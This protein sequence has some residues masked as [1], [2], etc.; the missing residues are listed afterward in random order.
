MKFKVPHNSLNLEELKNIL[1]TCNSNKNLDEKDDIEIWKNIE[2]TNYSVSTL[3]NICNNNTGRILIGTPNNNGYL[4]VNLYNK[5]YSVHRLVAI[6]FIPNPE[7]KPTVNH[8]TING[9]TNKQDNRA[10]SLEWATHREQNLHASDNGLASIGEDRFNSILDD[11]NVSLIKELISKGIRDHLIAEEFEVSHGTVQGIRF[12]R[13]WRHIPWPEGFN[14]YT[15]E[16]LSNRKDYKGAGNPSAK[17]DEEDVI[18]IRNASLKGST[19]SELSKQFG[20]SRGTVW[21]IVNRQT[22]KHIF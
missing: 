3:G 12:E 6:A 16:N 7:D 1:I 22:W 10:S 21:N 18:F 15:E 13:N 4:T 19:D 9:I 14:P 11:N 17:I 5:S 2:D 8:K 20:I